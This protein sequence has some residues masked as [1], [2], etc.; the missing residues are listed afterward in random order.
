MS[1]I[2]ENKEFG[3]AEQDAKTA[4]TSYV[5]KLKTPFTF[6]EKTY[7]SLTFNWG[8]L[9][10]NDSLAIEAEL[11]ALGKGLVA[12]EFSG[13]YLIR[14]AS[15]ACAEPLGVDAIAALPIG[16]FNR[17]RSKARSFLLNMAL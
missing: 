5:H 4:A 12:P 2:I 8:E 16:D 13:E 15:R 3:A 14:M 10:G 1:N 6:E 9:T 11:A 17:I 7:E